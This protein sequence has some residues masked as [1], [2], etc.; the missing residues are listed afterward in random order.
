MAE[1]V[2]TE[3]E[4]EKTLSSSEDLPA[5]KPHGPP[6]FPEGGGRAWAVALGCSGI[7]FCTFGYINAFG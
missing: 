7:L 6:D 3:M 4:V 1:A 2:P 5:E